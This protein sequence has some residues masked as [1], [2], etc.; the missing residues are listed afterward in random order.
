MGPVSES[1]PSAVTGPGS[2]LS[3]VYLPGHLDLLVAKVCWTVQ[4]YDLTTG[5]EELMTTPSQLL[6][7]IAILSMAISSK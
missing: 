1:R 2:A 3:S 5:W 4:V 7:S 6:L